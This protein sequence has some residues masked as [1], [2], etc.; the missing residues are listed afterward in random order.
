MCSIN[1]WRFRTYRLRLLSSSLLLRWIQM[2]ARPGPNLSAFVVDC[3][4]IWFQ[5]NL[6]LVVSYALLRVF[7]IMS[8]QNSHWKPEEGWNRDQYYDGKNKRNKFQSN[9]DHHLGRSDTHSFYVTNFPEFVLPSYMWR[10][11]S[12]FTIRKRK[13]VI[14]DWQSLTK[15]RGE[16]WFISPQL[17]PET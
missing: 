5:F 3:V 8:F 14:K 13:M 9:C 7:I 17:V 2:S 6:G 12:R 16:D 15:I 4:I 11:C 1:H 10:V